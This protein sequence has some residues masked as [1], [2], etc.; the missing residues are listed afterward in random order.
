MGGVHE[1]NS[2][3]NIPPPAP[4]SEGHILPKAWSVGCNAPLMTNVPVEAAATREDAGAITAKGG[5][6]IYPVPVKSEQDVDRDSSFK[7]ENDS[8]KGNSVA[9]TNVSVDVGHVKKPVMENMKRIKPDLT[10]RLR[11]EEKKLSLLDIQ[12]RL[13]DEI[14]EQ[15][16]D[17]LAL[18]DRPYRKF[19]RQ[20]ERQRQELMRQ[21]QQLQKET[22]EKQLKAPF[23]GAYFHRLSGHDRMNQDLIKVRFM[24]S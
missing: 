5:P 4:L 9:S 1:R 12:S 21:V 20:C 18:P 11:I 24:R 10:S 23:G 19:I 16:Q 2:K 13:R 7:G 8:E 15:Q 17:I 3:R 22:R 14:D 6:E